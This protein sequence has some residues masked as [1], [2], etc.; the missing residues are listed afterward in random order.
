MPVYSL[1]LAPLPVLRRSAGSEDILSSTGP[2]R[3]WIYHEPWIVGHDSPSVSHPA[4]STPGILWKRI[5]LFCGRVP[6]AV[7]QFHVLHSY[8]WFHRT[9][10]IPDDSRRRCWCEN[11]NRAAV[12]PHPRWRIPFR[13]ASSSRCSWME[14]ILIATW[15]SLSSKKRFQFVSLP[16]LTVIRFGLQS[17]SV[18]IRQN[19][20]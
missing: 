2:D 20:P 15:R 16:L 11:H 18:G 6:S 5:R 17:I 9:R 8:H 7:W 3:L 4:H 12:V 10:Y 14:V 13:R 19:P 1:S